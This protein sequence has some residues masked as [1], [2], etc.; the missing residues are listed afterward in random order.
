[1][2]IK[3]SQIFFFFA[4]LSLPSVS[5]ALP[6]DY[7]MYRQQSLQTNE[8]ARN[9]V[10]G[11]VPRG[12]EIFTYTIEEGSKKLKNEVPKDKYS[13]WRGRRLWNS[14]CWT[15][16]GKAGDGTGPVGSQLGVPNLLTD[17]YSKTPDGRVYSVIQLGLRNMPRYGFRFSPKE[18]W[19]IVNYLR[20][21][22]G[23]FDVEGIDKPQ[24]EDKKS[25]KE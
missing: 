14:N 23:T 24:V 10:K 1:M 6:G 3:R 16:H 2:L 25:N 18:K 13:V 9:P 20:F 19:D 15:C 21:L 17:Y 11:T 7:D 4:L 22:Q 8:V 12:R 5:M